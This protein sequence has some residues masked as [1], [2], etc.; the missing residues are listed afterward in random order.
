[1]F[2]SNAYNYLHVTKTQTIL[3]NGFLKKPKLLSTVPEM[4][5]SNINWT[6]KA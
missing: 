6:K 2:I 4:V 1:M 3:N 5:F